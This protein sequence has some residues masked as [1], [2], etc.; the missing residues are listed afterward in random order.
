MEFLGRSAS[1]HMGKGRN[2][3]FDNIRRDL[4]LRPWL[5]RL[6]ETGRLAIAKPG[7]GLKFE[8]AAIA[9]RL[10]GR[11]ASLFPNP[12]GQ[13]GAVVSGLISDR[14]WMAEVLGLESEADLVSAYQDA[15]ANPIPWQEVTT[16]PCQQVVHE[17]PDL[18]KLLP[19]PTH[20]ELDSGPYISAGL[21]ITRNPRNGI[22]NVS[23]HRLQLSGPNELGALILPRHTLT[24]FE[25]GEDDGVDLDI[26]I[27]IGA[28]PAA[29]LAS[30]AVVP[31][32][33]D[34]LTIAGALGG[35]P[36]EVA[37]CLGSEIR[38]PANAE[39]VLEGKILAKARAPEG[40]F[41]EFPQYYGAR[42]ERH[43]I[44]VERVTHREDP[45][46]HTIT[47][48][49]LEHLLLGAIPRESTILTTLQRSFPCVRDVHLSVGG[50]MRY[51]LYVQ[52]EKPKAGEA[53]NV[54]AA[55]LGA[56]YDIKHVVVVDTDVDIFDAE[57]VEWAVATRFQ[58]HRDLVVIEGAQG[59]KLDPTT[60]DEGVG[61]K[62][63]L[64][65]TIP[66]GASEFTFTT[67]RVPGEA[68]VDL[69][70]AIDAGA[71]VSDIVKDGG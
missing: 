31:I 66:A 49:R 60:D 55:A 25:M 69:D 23:I 45:I 28:S 38:V 68:E 39:I 16:P 54:L 13:D 62:M 35:A 17:D 24:Y 14:A 44:R 1:L 36:V 6:A 3:V 8:L 43:V 48:G 56:H 33:F 11:Q 61:S 26:A 47:G 4:D 20:N 5:R 21:A 57:K 7:V 15:V 65:A 18:G 50:T 70:A 40:P 51:H 42:A 58:A 37:K 9:N 53:K 71:K 34:E 27:V 19:I 30:Q 12:G 63:G 67:I 29:L 10:D 41:G 59:S 32:D 64:D 52:V 22:Q 46:Y 2:A